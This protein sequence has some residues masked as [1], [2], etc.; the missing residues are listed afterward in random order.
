MKFT[1][2]GDVH[3][4]LNRCLDVATKNTDRTIIQIGDLGVGFIP[5]DI[6]HRLPENFRF[7]VGN[8][9]NRQLARK[10]PYCLGDFGEA[11]NRFFFV[12]GADSIDKNRRIENV[13]WWKDEELTYV[14][15]EQC[16]SEWEKSKVDVLVT[17]DCPQ[18]FAEQ[19]KLIYDRTLTRNLIQSMINVRKPKMIITG[20]HHRSNRIQ[21]DGIDWVELGIDETFDLDIL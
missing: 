20:H 5:F 7:F 15:A 8:H 13:S 1:F 9:D 2:L 4:N 3:T 18:S 12:S 10:L 21:V 11:Y 16:F 6:F 17:H 19:F 14:Q